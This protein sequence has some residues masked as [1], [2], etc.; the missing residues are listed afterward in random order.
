MKVPVRLFILFESAILIFLLDSGF[1]S[2]TFQKVYSVS[3]NVVISEI[4]V[5]SDA[6]T[7]DE[8]VELYNPSGSPVDLTGW[9][10]ARKTQSGLT[11]NNLIASMSGTIPAKGYFLIASPES[12]ASGSADEV[13][14][15]SSH[16]SVDN[17]VLLFGADGTT[18]VDMVGM[19]VSSA[20]ETASIDNPISGGS[21][22][23]KAQSSSSDVTMGLGG[24]D[25]FAGNGWDTD[26][27]SADFL[28]RTVSQ[29][30][31]SLSTIEPPI[32][33]TP[34]DTAT[35][36]PSETV[37]PTPTETPTPSETPTPTP[38]ETPIPTPTENPTPTTTPTPT[39]LPTPTPSPTPFIVQQFPIPGGVITCTWTRRALP[40]RRF[41]FF[42]PVVQ[43]KT[44]KI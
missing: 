14:G 44:V 16:I 4:Q 24:T 10:L 23:R 31:N 6:D 12:L 30:Q 5:R 28:E 2:F 29:P 13:Y 34:T 36:T 41:T 8:F 3:P 38:T 19:G 7:D 43:C 21:V 1:R 15:T 32:L 11:Q 27:N 40:I 17:T 25:E 22:E 9:K 26:D 39:I 42:L 18:L 37:T 20:S 33:P 35:P